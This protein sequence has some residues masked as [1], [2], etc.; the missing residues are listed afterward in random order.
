MLDMTAEGNV[1]ILLGDP[2]RA[3]RAM[4]V[5]LLIALLVVQ[6][7]ALAD[8]AWCSGLGTEALAATAIC[9]PLYEVITGLGTGLGVGGAAV[10][11]RYIGSGS[12][13]EASRGSVQTMLFSL[14]F[15]I[16][17]T[18]ILVLLCRDILVLVGSGD[19]TDVSY[20][21]MIW[22]MLA[23]PV[24]ILNGAV[25]GLIRGEGAA[26]MS[27]VMMV[28]L[29]LGNIVLDPI[30]IYGA[31][32]GI[33]GASVATV[34]ATVVSTVIGLQYYRAS[35]YIRLRGS[36]IRLESGMML[37]VLRAG[38]PQMAE[39]TVM[40]AMNLVLNYLVIWCAGSEG[41]AVYSVPNMVVNIA[42]L[43]AYA[44]GS[45]LVPVAS[46]AYGRG[47]L[48]KMREAYRYSL[49]FSMGMVIVLTALLLLIPDPFIYPFTYSDGTEYLREDMAT[50]LRIC[51]L[52]IPFY[53]I[54]PLGSSMLQALALPNW[55][56]AMSF[57]RN[58]VFIGLYAAGATVSLTWIYWAV[59]VGSVIGGLMAYCLA[60]RGFRAAGTRAGARPV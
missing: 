7:N 39:Y 31:G 16:L 10:V 35:S 6:V 32:M 5:P 21:Y 45:A 26:R 24:F 18:P 15:G 60:S 41:L 19:V 12:R 14:I 50:A 54:I 48:D 34:L 42:L 38:I 28:V 49:R 17:L 9:A 56:L 59:V 13:G 33:A 23:T 1:S 51:S 2:R 43:P 36:D 53:S 22:I 25:A 58:F 30:L 27:T 40:Y 11:S 57:V 20:D 8:R 37:T 3:I 29:A 55:S 4:T 44:V 47:D 52:C 46:A